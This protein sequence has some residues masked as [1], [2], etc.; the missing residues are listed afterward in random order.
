MHASYYVCVCVCELICVRWAVY[1]CVCVC[2]RDM[3][4]LYYPYIYPRGVSD[5][6]IKCTRTPLRKKFRQKNNLR[7]VLHNIKTVCEQKSK[8]K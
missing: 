3:Q 2:V 6:K 1:M 4:I 5:K 7:N 8:Y